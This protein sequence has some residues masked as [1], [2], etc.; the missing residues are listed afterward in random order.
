ME[1]DKIYPFS[2]DENEAR[3]LE[4]APAFFLSCL[5][6][7]LVIAIMAIPLDFLS[8]Q[9]QMI[10]REIGCKATTIMMMTGF[11]IVVLAFAAGIPVIC[12]YMFRLIS[13]YVITKDNK[14]YRIRKRTKSR[15]Y[16]SSG[17]MIVQWYL[18]AT[19]MADSEYV[20][21]I[22]HSKIHIPEDVS[23]EQI[24][25]NRVLHESKKSIT[26][27]CNIEKRTKKKKKTYTNK[28]LKIIKS[29]ENVDELCIWI[30]SQ[31]DRK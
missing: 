9:N 20:L 7:G 24:Q 30:H 11:G 16:Q 14:L 8:S 25:L 23:L 1:Q 29:V 18:N 13:T 10:V 3:N 19:L 26:V 27:L 22:I 4:I 5:V 17:G 21:S 28:R 12:S 15:G 2:D 31:G 6:M